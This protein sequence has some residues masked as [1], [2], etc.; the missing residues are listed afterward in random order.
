MDNKKASELLCSL[1]IRFR[2]I[3]ENLAAL[4][5]TG[6]AMDSSGD[7][8]DELAKEFMAMDVDKSESDAAVRFAGKLDDIISDIRYDHCIW[9]IRDAARAARSTV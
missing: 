5:G 3:A 8:Y 6:I 9:P 4:R 1:H 2:D 7:M